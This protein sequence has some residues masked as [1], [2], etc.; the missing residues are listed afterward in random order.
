MREISSGEYKKILLDIMDAIDSFCH[1]NKIAYYMLGGTLLGAVRHHGFIPWDDDMDIGLKREDYDRFC[2][3]FNEHRDDPYRVIHLNN[4]ANYYSPSA[5]VIDT[6]TSLIENAYQAIEIGAYIDVFPLD[7]ISEQSFKCAEILLSHSSIAEKL[8]STKTM[9]TSKN[10]KWYKNFAIVVSRIL[11]YK[12]INEIAKEYD[13]KARQL[14]GSYDNKYIANLCGAWG[15]KEIAEASDFDE[16]IELLF[17]NR[18]YMAPKG[19]DS[20]L[21][22]LYGEYMELPPLEKRVTHHDN[23]VKWKELYQ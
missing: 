1:Q 22:R 4:T 16:T 3:Q 12:S 23:C 18:R 9:N 8:K 2:T 13:E 19:Y 17:E 15:K 10:R 14:S 21:R 7:Y 5:K 6:R 20:Y 11:C